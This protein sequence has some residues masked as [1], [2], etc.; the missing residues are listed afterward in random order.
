M[1]LE[2]NPTEEEV[3]GQIEITEKLNE[4]MDQTDR[5]LTRITHSGF[6]TGDDKQNYVQY[7]YNL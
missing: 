4:A 6:A 7:A 1:Y 2:P 5:S 3:E